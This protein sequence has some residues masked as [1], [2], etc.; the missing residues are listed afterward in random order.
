MCRGAKTGPVAA[1]IIPISTVFLDND[2]KLST[3]YK[4]FRFVSALQLFSSSDW[5]NMVL[6]TA[7]VHSVV[8]RVREIFLKEIHILELYT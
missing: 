2:I 6:S 7:F 5:L 4:H 1:L 3:N 8:S